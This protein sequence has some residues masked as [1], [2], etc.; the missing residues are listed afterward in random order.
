M[1]LSSAE[2]ELEMNDWYCF[3]TVFST[4]RFDRMFTKSN[5]AVV[6]VVR[7]VRTLYQI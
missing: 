2:N 6:V 4:S 1:S 7:N 3:L 5:C